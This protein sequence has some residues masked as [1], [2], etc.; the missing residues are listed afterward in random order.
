DVRSHALRQH[1]GRAHGGSPITQVAFHPTRD[2]LL[3]AS[4]DRTLRLWDLRAGRLRSTIVGHNRPVLACSWDATGERF[5]SC[6]GEL[7]HFWAS[8]PSASGA[9]DSAPRRAVVVSPTKVSPAPAAKF[10]PPARGKPVPEAARSREEPAVVEPGT[11]LGNLL[12]VAWGPASSEM[13]LPSAPPAAAAANEALPEVMA[14]FME[15]LVSK[16]D[17][18]TLSLQGLESRLARS[19]AATAEVMELVQTQRA[20]AMPVSAVGVTQPAAAETTL[21]PEGFTD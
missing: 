17:V 8:E 3:S 4:A 7:V 1:Y 13:P 20:A 6:D 14:R 12:E 19:E 16:M 11:H 5:A 21:M 15:Q 18:L 10:L 9:A 2:L